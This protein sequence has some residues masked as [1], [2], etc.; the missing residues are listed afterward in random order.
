MYIGVSFDFSRQTNMVSHAN[1]T[2]MFF[3]EKIK[4]ENSVDCEI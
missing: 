3:R 1:K 4:E 2:K